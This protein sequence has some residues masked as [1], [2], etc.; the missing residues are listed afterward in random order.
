MRLA[1]NMAKLYKAGFS[2]AAME[3]TQQLIMK[4]HAEFREE[5]K[6]CLKFHAHIN[7]KA[8]IDRHPAMVREHQIQG[9]LPCQMAQ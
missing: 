1:L 4:P 2:R 7:V 8:A 3:E 6:L 9:F 5:N